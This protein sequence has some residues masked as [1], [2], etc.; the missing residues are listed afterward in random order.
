MNTLITV[1]G[2]E[3]RYG[4]SAVIHKHTSPA[5]FLLDP[6]NFYQKWG[7]SVPEGLHHEIEI[8]RPSPEA[9]RVKVIHVHES[10]KCTG[11]LICYPL[12]IPTIA[13]ATSVFRT[14]ALGT[15]LTWETDI[16][17]NTLRDGECKGDD[18]LFESIL[19]ERHGIS[20]GE[21]LHNNP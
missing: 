4:F 18:S 6:E 17:L 2:R 13:K 14:W 15:V 20:L 5:T 19:K 12:H 8:I 10:P 11:L 16:D 9:L 1:Q 21:L 7:K 3:K